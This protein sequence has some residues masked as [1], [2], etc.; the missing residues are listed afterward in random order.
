MTMSNVGLISVMFQLHDYF[1]NRNKT[2]L[3]LA[4]IGCIVIF[5]YGSRN[6]FIAIVIYVFVQLLDVNR[7][8]SKTGNKILLFVAGI[9]SILFLSNG[10]MILLAIGSLLDSLGLSSRSLYFLIN[11]NDEDITTGRSDI[12]DKLWSVIWDNPIF[13]TGI[14][15]DEAN[16][17]EYR[18]LIWRPVN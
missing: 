1:K 15:G 5:L 9:F 12:H 16:I 18:M 10:K 17:H 6:P 13:G 11:E 8:G 2:S 7:G 14:A 4:L 3:L